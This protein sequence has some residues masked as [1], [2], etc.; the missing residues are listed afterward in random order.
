[1]RKF[2]DKAEESDL[3][4]R[5]RQLLASACLLI[6]TFESGLSVGYSAVLLPQLQSNT[7]KDE[8]FRNLSSEDLTWVASS[9]IVPM[10]P[11]SWVAGLLC[12][13]IGRRWC[14]VSC[15]LMMILG[16]LVISF[17][18]GI[19][20][21]IIG[22]VMCGF[23]GGLIGTIL[24]VFTS[25]ITD[26]ALRG[27]LLSSSI[28]MM[29]FGILLV[30]VL[31]L[32]LHWKTTA[33]V[34][35]AVSVLGLMTCSASQ[36][37]PTWLLTKGDTDRA[38]ESW[39]YLRGHKSLGEY[40]ALENLVTD[41]RKMGDQSTLSELKWTLTSRR[42]LYP[43]A[44][45]C[46]CFSLSIFNGNAVLV[47]YS[48]DMLVDVIGP[49]YADLGTVVI[50]ATR[51]LISIFA[52]YFIKLCKRRTLTFVSG[53]VTAATLFLL[54]LD[55]YFNL[56]KPWCPIVLV[57]VAT[58]ST[59]IGLAP[60]PWVLCGELF[61][62]KCRG[63]ASGLCLG[64]YY[65]FFFIGVK[66]LPAMM[67]TLQLYGSFA[68]YGVITLLGT[69]FLYFT[70]PETKD[71]TLQD[72]EESFDRKVDSNNLRDTESPRTLYI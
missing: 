44:I 6:A 33:Y 14:I 71:R 59:S 2:L 58:V 1:M 8:G 54:C 51:C 30:H 35:V 62:S 25:E 38:I 50:D 10:L 31:G 68:V 16:W 55:L 53:Y 4:L 48:V 42:F 28:A 26:P 56:G 27:I 52:S 20:T 49:E 5:S 3:V 22:R 72:I 41:E 19:T 63:L 57:L 46:V 39:V 47:F 64:Y 65:L 34:C 66:F 67:E 17:A 9:V 45:L 60:L 32:L 24:P 43:I 61:S 15:H 70:L 23:A 7:T 11:G 12:D 40:V 13:M 18:G 21:L 37:S 29:A 69:I 36:E